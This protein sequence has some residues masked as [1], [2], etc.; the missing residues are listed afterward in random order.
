V[1]PAVRLEYSIAEGGRVLHLPAHLPHGQLV[2]LLKAYQDVKILHFRQ[3]SMSL[4]KLADDKLQ[5]T[6][7]K[8]VARL[9]ESF[10]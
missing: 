1:I 9:K 3:P 7:D 5:E 2:D 10:A 6:L 4:L 8:R